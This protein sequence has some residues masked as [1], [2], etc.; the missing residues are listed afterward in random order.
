MT[1]SDDLNELLKQF[2]HGGIAYQEWKLR[3]SEW[4]IRSPTRAVKTARKQAAIEYLNISRRTIERWLNKF[5][6]TEL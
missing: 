6:C 5:T 3:I 4:V 2:V 1:D